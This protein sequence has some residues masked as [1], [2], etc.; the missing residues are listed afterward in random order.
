MSQNVTHPSMF[1]LSYSIQYL[2]VFIYF[3]QHILI[4]DVSIQRILSIFLRIHILKASLCLSAYRHIYMSVRVYRHTRFYSPWCRNYAGIIYCDRCPYGE[5][6]LLNDRYSIDLWRRYSVTAFLTVYLTA[7][8][9]ETTTRIFTL[10]IV[11][12]GAFSLAKEAAVTGTCPSVPLPNTTLPLLF[13]SRCF[14]NR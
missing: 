14:L 1:P 2:L 6:R 10:E 11:Y 3:P 5:K 7:R 8:M 13:M 4:S 9:V 12:F